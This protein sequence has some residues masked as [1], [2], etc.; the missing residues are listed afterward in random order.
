V[1]NLTQELVALGHH[2][3]L[4]CA[5]GAQ[6]DA[7]QV[8]TV[9]YPLGDWPEAET[10]RPREYD[11]ETGYLEGPPDQRVWEQ[12]HIAT[13]MEAASSGRFD[14]IHSHLHVH[15]LPFSRL[16]GCPLVSSLHGAAWARWHHP[17]FSEY[18]RCPFVSLSNA[19]R[20]LFPE[21]HYVDTVYNGV[22]LDDFP[23]QPN[24]EDFLLFAGRLSPEKGPVEAI[25]VAKKTGRRLVLAGMV[26]PQH[27]AYF[28]ENIKPHLDGKQ[29]E[30]VGL[31]TQAELAPLYRNAAAVLFLINW[32]EPCSMVGIEAQ[33]SGT[34]LIG[35]RYGYLPEII[36]DGQTGFLVDTLDEACE[37]VQRLG[38][39][40]PETC[41]RNCE[42]RFSAPVM[43]RGYEA[44][45]RG[46]VVD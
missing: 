41:R 25:Q 19:E 30:Y 11:P 33:A 17:L 45:F 28:D 14:L 23:L 42:E 20:Q 37:A 43:A 44:V 27:Q 5:A 46:L 10:N 6:T 4:F 35:T 9:P 2:V 39:L 32:C 16:I 7:E 22:R 36:V 15:A 38:D 3:T 13:C 34:P 26:E 40:A 8:E 1:F 18:R 12:K 24:K 29:I 21:L 31:L